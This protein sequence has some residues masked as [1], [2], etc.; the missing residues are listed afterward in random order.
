MPGAR[1]LVRTMRAHGASTA[2][3]SGGFTAFTRHVQALCGFDHEEANELEIVGDRLTG[4]LVGELRGAAA[5]LEH[6]GAAARE[7]WG[8]PP[9]TTLAVGDGAND[10]PMLQGAGLGVAFRAHERVRAAAP[11][12]IDHGDLTALLFL[13][14]YRRERVRRR[15][16][17]YSLNRSATKRRS[18][19]RSIS[20]RIDFLPS[21]LA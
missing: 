20:S 2:L 1:T 8:S 16:S 7:L 11:V 18:P 13:Q 17:R 19:W 15:L 10:L 6:A 4:R 5:K 12:R 9:A 21:S 3:V 14:G